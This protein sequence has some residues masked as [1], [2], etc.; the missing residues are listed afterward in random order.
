VTLLVIDCGIGNVGAV[1]SMYRRLGHHAEL[2]DAP[3][4]LK[5]GDRLILP[6]VGA[7][8][9][10]A[11]AIERRGFVPFLRDA[12][13]AGHPLLGICLGMQLLC[14]GS[15][16]GGRTGLG[17]VQADVVRL[18]PGPGRVRIPHMGWNVVTPR[19]ANPLLPIGGEEQRFY[20]THS[21]R[22]R[23]DREDEVWATTVHGTEFPSAIGSGNVMGVQFHPEKSHRFGKALLERFATLA[24]ADA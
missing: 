7:F 20:F 8:D 18:D 2:I 23:C 10:G 12:A 16:E 13:A 6:G 5:P 11:E 21:Y 4:S 15:E 1:R 22:V 24:M 19:R 3:R 14:R 17:L 9:F